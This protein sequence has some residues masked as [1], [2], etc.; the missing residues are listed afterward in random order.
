MIPVPNPRG[1]TLVPKPGNPNVLSV[2][3]PA[4]D[5]SDVIGRAVTPSF[6][7]SPSGGVE[8]AAAAPPSGMDEEDNIPG[9]DP[10]SAATQGDYYGKRTRGDEE[11]TRNPNDEGIFIPDALTGTPL[12][13]FDVDALR[14]YTQRHLAVMHEPVVKFSASVAQKIGKD[15]EEMLVNGGTLLDPQAR[16]VQALF[17]TSPLSRASAAA[18]A[19]VAQAMAQAVVELLK[20]NPSS[21]EG[22]QQQKKVKTEVTSVANDN[23]NPVNLKAALDPVTHALNGVY[24]RVGV[25]NV[26][27]EAVRDMGRQPEPDADP[28]A[29]LPATS[30]LRQLAVFLSEAKENEPTARW[31]WNSLP[32]N[33]GIAIIRG[34]VVAAMEDCHAIIRESIPD[35]QMWHL[36]TGPHVRGPFAEMVAEYINQAPGEL[37]FPNFQSTRGGNVLTGTRIS[38]GK[39]REERAVQRLRYL[40]RWFSNVAYGPSEA[41]TYAQEQPELARKQLAVARVQIVKWLEACQED[42]TTLWRQLASQPIA[43]GQGNDRYAELIEEHTQYRVTLQTAQQQRRVA[44][45]NYQKGISDEVGEAELLSRGE[46]ANAARQRVLYAKQDL[47]FV[48]TDL[49]RYANEGLRRRLGV[50]AEHV[51]ALYNGLS[52]KDEPTIVA[53]CNE[54]YQALSTIVSSSNSLYPEAEADTTLLLKLLTSV[55]SLKQAVAAVKD[56]QRA[57]VK[58]EQNMLTFPEANKRELFHK[59]PAA[60]PGTKALLTSYLNPGAGLYASW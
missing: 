30:I 37:Q 25:R 16:S 52:R 44:D 5:F 58:A 32:E 43:A 9:L 55:T 28:T 56:A 38:A 29:E 51:Y 2:Y 45:M 11:K 3:Q 36:I 41:W 8:T 21:V 10:P 39:F 54:L 4:T 1:R 15:P 57:V 18:S 19:A 40:K 26:F 53:A 42:V 33:S 14:R 49:Q 46:V 50:Q 13:P 17:T 48:V 35:V 60:N 59:A 20:H 34:D 12:D 7:P 6:V 27:R 31:V 24:E 23:N 22:E 47:E